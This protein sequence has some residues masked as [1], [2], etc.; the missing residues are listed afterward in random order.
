MHDRPIDQAHALARDLGRAL[1]P[2]H[3]HGHLVA[4]PGCAAP[5]FREARRFVEMTLWML[6]RAPHVMVV[7]FVGA[8]AQPAAIVATWDSRGVALWQ[9]VASAEAFRAEV[10]AAAEVLAAR[11]AHDDRALIEALCWEDRD[12]PELEHLEFWPEV[13]GRLQAGG[14]GGVA[15]IEPGAAVPAPLAERIWASRLED[16]RERLRAL[17][18]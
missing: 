5:T 15:P 6:W 13:L 3:C 10:A 7:P 18:D 16:R 17:D 2:L 9:T 14:A 1:R 4:V 12:P 11:H 8:G